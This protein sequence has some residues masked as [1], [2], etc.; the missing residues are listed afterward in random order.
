MRRTWMRVFGT[1]FVGTT[2]LMG[3]QH[4]RHCDS[5]SGGAPVAPAAS[6]VPAQKMPSASTYHEIM[7][8]PNAVPPMPLPEPIETTKLPDPP[9]DEAATTAELEQ[10][11][12]AREVADAKKV[13][14]SRRTFHDITAD[15]CFDHAA[16]YAWVTGELYFE[17]DSK[18]WTVRYASVDEEDRYGGKVTLTDAGSMENLRSGQM[19]RVEGRLA[20]AEAHDLRPAYKVQAIKLVRD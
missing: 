11:A 19:V 18:T 12:Y 4:S 6:Y 9:E 13:L 7:R 17:K 8:D 2:L 16:D 15:P 14:H 1:G 10:A 3:C 20:D 5:C